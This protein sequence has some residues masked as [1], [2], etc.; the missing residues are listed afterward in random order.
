VI[1]NV[2][3]LIL[4]VPVL[5]LVGCATSRNANPSLDSQ[6]RKGLEIKPPILFSL[7]DG[8]VPKCQDDVIS[9][10][11]TDLERIYG[12]SIEWADYFASTPKDRVSI[13]LRIVK[14]G[15]SFGSRIVS[16][17]AFATATATA[18]GRATGP[19]SRVVLDISSQQSVLTSSVQTEGWW[20]GAAWVDVELEDARGS[21]Q[22]TFVMPIVS[23]HQ[24]SNVWGYSS[25]DEAAQV[26][27][28]QAA[29]QLTRALDM[30]FRTVRDTNK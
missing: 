28:Q 11:K 14:L 17:A 21:R 24:E 8:R 6:P 12:S 15:A 19:W 29:T 10:I 5:L 2:L 16:S 13:R 18:H 9:D 20:N 30:V 26:A 1:K 27:W 25:G 7:F 22:I 23:E 3:L 4:I